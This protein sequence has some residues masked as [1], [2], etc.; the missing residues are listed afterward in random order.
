MIAARR[1][2]GTPPSHSHWSMT[3]GQIRSVTAPASAGEALSTVGNCS[4]RPARS[5][6]L[7][8]R[9]RHPRR[10]SSVPMIAIGTTG[11]PVSS[12]SRP[13]PRLGLPSAPGRVRVPSGNISTISPRSRMI[14]AV[15]IVSWSPAPRSTGKAPSA[16][17]SQLTT[18]LY[19]NSSFLAT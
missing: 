3:I 12:A 2:G 17:S 19:A 14:L 6:T 11:A 8:G 10:M 18:R 16:S 1:I 4:G 9:I 13:T 7:R 5:L 15:S